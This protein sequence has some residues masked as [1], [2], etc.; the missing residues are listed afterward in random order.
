[1]AR[2]VLVQHDEFLPKILSPVETDFSIRETYQ[3]FRFPSPS[4][5]DM[6]K[7]WASNDASSDDHSRLSLP[8]LESKVAFVAAIPL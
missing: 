6:E 2:K 4:S 5:I 3:A 8:F 1:M 7:F